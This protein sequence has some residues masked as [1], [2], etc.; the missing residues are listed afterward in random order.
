MPYD[1][2]RV[3]AVP[4]GSV[5]KHRKGG[6]VAPLFVRITYARQGG[7]EVRKA[8]V[9]CTLDASGQVASLA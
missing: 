4:A 3:E 7:Y 8:R 5:G 9:K 2:V 6:M 1:P